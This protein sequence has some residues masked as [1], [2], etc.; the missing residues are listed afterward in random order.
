MGQVVEKTA[1]TIS[2]AL[3]DALE[4]LGVS[5]EQVDYEVLDYPSKGLFGVLGAKPARIRVKL[6]EPRYRR[7]HEPARREREEEAPDVPEQAVPEPR[8]YHLVLNDE[9]L[10]RAKAFLSEIF[11][12][13]ELEVEI[14]SETTEEGYVIRL[15][16]KSLG[17]LIGKRGQTLDA[18]QYLTNLA[19][20]RGESDRIRVI[21]DIENYRDRREETLRNLAKRLADKAVRMHQD[22]KLEPMNRHE[23]KVIHVALQENRRVTTTSE[24]EEP[25]RYVIIMPNKSRNGGRRR[26]EKYDN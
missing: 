11:R 5:E 16:G 12:V 24:G 1:K 19:A 14:S 3:A 13:M 9:S 8:E 26:S 6:R 10:A 21:L 23:R 25:Y 7:H 4:E 2:Q 20:N 22:V 15:E 18:L 17:I